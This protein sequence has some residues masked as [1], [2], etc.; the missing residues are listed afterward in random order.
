MGP[1]DPLNPDPLDLIDAHLVA[2][3]IIELRGAR[4]GVLCHCRRLLK[5]APALEIRRDPRC[6]KR[7]IANFGGDA[8]RRRAL[9]DHRIGVCLRQQRPRELAYAAPDRAGQRPL[10]IVAQARAVDIGGQV[11]LEAMMARHAVALA[12]L[13]AEPHP[14]AAVLPYTSSTYIPSAAP[15]RAKE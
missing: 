5:R 10:G 14:E 12:A 13:L 2:S 9:V 3:A 11:F 8:G 15:I 1:H 7:V 4:A 6:P